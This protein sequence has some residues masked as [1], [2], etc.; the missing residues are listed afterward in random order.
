MADLSFLKSPVVLCSCGQ[1]GLRV[2][3]E[4]DIGEVSVEWWCASGYENDGWRRRLVKA[5]R[6][7]R[8]G[9]VIIHDV[10][11]TPRIAR[12]V[13]CN[14]GAAAETAEKASGSWT[15]NQ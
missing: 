10:H 8:Q 11:L 4:D 14:L 1:H 13:A 9:L 2:T 5:W 6:L 15:S 12:E 7:L 3:A